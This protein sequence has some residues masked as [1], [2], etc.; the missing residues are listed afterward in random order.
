MYEKFMHKNHKYKKVDIQWS[1]AE[2]RSRA[3]LERAFD[4]GRFSDI[5]D[6]ALVEATLERLME[7]YAQTVKPLEEAYEF[8]D[9]SEHAFHEG[10]IFS[11]PMISFLGPWSTG[12]SSLINYVL[13]IENTSLALKSGAQPTTS[14]FSILSY[15]DISK[16]VEGKILVMEKAYSS[17]LKYGQ[18]F[19]ERLKSYAIPNDILKMVHLVDTPGVMENRKQQERGYPF[20][21]ICGWFVERSD[22]VV[23]VFDPAKMDVGRELEQLFQ[24]IKGNEA[25]V[26]IV[27]NKADTLPPH[28]LLRVY[29]SLL[30]NL[31]PLLNI[32]DAPRMYVS[33]FWS[34]PFLNPSKE[35]AEM[36]VADETSLLHDI[37]EVMSNRLLNKI[38]YLR[39]HAVLVRNHALV[40]DGYLSTLSRQRSFFQSV[41]DVVATITENPQK[42][43]SKVLSHRDVTMKDL[44]PPETYATF[45]SVHSMES[46]ISL[47]KHCG[48]LSLCLLEA[49]EK[50]IYEDLPRLSI[51]VESKQQK[52]CP[53]SQTC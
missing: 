50:T 36:F 27:L 32:T 52:T 29:G 39:R 12:K 41:G 9:I 18:S 31:S 46:F 2:I 47:S 38:A 26:R 28:E 25:K 42:I 8:N 40:V 16:T 45:F 23:F 48:F 34:K 4:S 37:S 5:S 13:G 43:Y 20:A 35:F 17:L 6:A 3:H 44:F 53:S 15:K 11:L 14:D 24:K 7:L 49:I 30:W 1:N 19:L 22:L 21:G 51:E 10:E 33:S